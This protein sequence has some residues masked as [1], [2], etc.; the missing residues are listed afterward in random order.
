M[1]GASRPVGL[2]ALFGRPS[3]RALFSPRLVRSPTETGACLRVRLRCLYVCVRLRCLYV[4][5]RV[6]LRCLY[7]CVRVCMVGRCGQLLADNW[8]AV[9]CPAHLPTCRLVATSCNNNRRRRRGPAE[10]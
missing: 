6:R 7:V 8:L 3:C 4:C 9:C 5:L 1:T 10:S 2:S